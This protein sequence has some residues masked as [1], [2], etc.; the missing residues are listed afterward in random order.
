VADRLPKE[1]L[2]KAGDP[3]FVSRC[4]HTW[5]DGK[6]LADLCYKAIAKRKTIMVIASCSYMVE[7]AKKALTDAGLPFHN[8]YRMIRADWNPLKLTVGT[9]YAERL[10]AFFAPQ[11]RDHNWWT[12]VELKDF[13][14][15]LKA[16][17]VFVKGMK[18]KLKALDNFSGIDTM[19]EF[20]AEA[21]VNAMMHFNLDWWEANLVNDEARRKANYALKIARDMGPLFLDA[22]TMVPEIIIGTIHSVK[23]GEADVVIVIPDLSQ[24][25]M[26]EWTGSGKS[27]IRRLM[28]VAMTRAKEGLIVCR[29]ASQY[30]CDL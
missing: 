10:K 5:K 4:P 17:G 12:L 13:A 19:F 26:Q 27:A 23:G 21:A 22:E 29:P 18:G 11:L 30:T 1:Y 15:C 7:P 25:G 14:E 16:D 6:A 9:T 2:P 3:G 24:E 8:P 28:Y 20:F